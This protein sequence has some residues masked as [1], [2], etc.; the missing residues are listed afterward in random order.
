MPRLLSA[1]A[2]PR[3]APALARTGDLFASRNHHHHRQHLRSVC[4]GGT[5]GGICIAAATATFAPAQHTLARGS[6]RAIVGGGSGHRRSFGAGVSAVPKAD[7]GWKPEQTS[8][9]LECAT[10]GDVDGLERLGESRHGDTALMH[11]AQHGHLDMASAL[12]SAGKVHLCFR[13]RAHFAAAAAV[14]VR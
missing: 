14:R 4:G 13:T 9:L 5:G 11:A 7:D 8:A 2:K 6:A 1:A 12:V 3:A 10:S